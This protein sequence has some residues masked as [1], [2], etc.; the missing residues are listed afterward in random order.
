MNQINAKWAAA[1][2]APLTVVMALLALEFFAA[3]NIDAIK[4]KILFWATIFL[5]LWCGLT[6]YKIKGRLRAVPIIGVIL[7]VG[8]AIW[9]DF[10][11]RFVSPS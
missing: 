3:D 2:V 8:L 5:I 6:A 11:V 7:G 1:G 4:V 9:A 10:I